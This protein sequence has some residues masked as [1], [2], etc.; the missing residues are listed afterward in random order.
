MR[1][2]LAMTAVTLVVGFG[3]VAALADETAAV[4]GPSYAA[5]GG[6]VRAP[7]GGQYV[8]LDRALQ[9]LE[10]E[11]KIEEFYADLTQQ[12]EGLSRLERLELFHDAEETLRTLVLE[13][14]TYAGEHHLKGE[15]YL[16]DARHALAWHLGLD[17]TPPKATPFS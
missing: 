9:R 12:A 6:D 10:L 5:A 4:P 1:L 2:F 8:K 17:E 3:T 13:S 15:E 7:E 14:E 16:D 11:A